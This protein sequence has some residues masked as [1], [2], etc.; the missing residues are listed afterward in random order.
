MHIRTTVLS[1]FSALVVALLVCAIAVSAQD[2]KPA[3]KPDKAQQAEIAAVVKIVDDG[4]RGQAAP[5]DYKFTWTNHS[6]KSRDGKAYVPFILTF[7]KGLALPASATYYIRV[8]NKATIADAQKATAAHNAA[9]EKAATAAKLDPENTDLAENE[10]KLRAQ[11]PKPDY[12]FEDIKFVNF[13][14]AQ[15]NAAFRFPAA[16]AVAGGDYDVYVL[17]KESAATLKDKKAQPKAGLLK[18]ALTVPN[19]WTEELDTSSVIITNI[20]EQLKAPPTDAEM[21]RSPYIFGLTKVTPSMDFK[22]AKKDELSILFYIYNTGF[23]KTTGKPDLTV[24]YNFYHKVDGVEKFFNKT[25]PQVLNASTLGQ[26]FDVKAGHQLLGGQGLPLAS[27]PEGEYRL[28]IKIVD[29]ITGK[30]KIENSLFTVI[31]G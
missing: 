15:P 9:V 20:T 28:E 25:N 1:V 14:N 19:Y 5:S 17:V 31:A 4:M 26:Q 24:D 22:F 16:M 23:D 21:V 7:D 8:V 18:V 3:A 13:T 6:M 2:K 27:F 30:T 12:A 10:A 29:K 11:G